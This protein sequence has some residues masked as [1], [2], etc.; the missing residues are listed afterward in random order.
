MIT[1]LLMNLLSVIILTA[2]APH[3]L[4]FLERLSA[5]A[6][7]ERRQNN[8]ENSEEMSGKKLIIQKHV[9]SNL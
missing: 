6:A 3:T 4:L 8:S 2:W 7:A 9:L 1:P 5:A